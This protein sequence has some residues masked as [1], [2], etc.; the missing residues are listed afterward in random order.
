MRRTRLDDRTA[1]RLTAGAVTPEDAP[2]GYAGV[3]GLLQA[4]RTGAAAQEL[5]YEAATVASMRS[6]LLGH[7]VPLSTSRRKKMISKVLTAKAAAL[8]GVAVLGGGGVAAAATG[9]LPASVQST[10]SSALS[11][12]DISVPNPNHHGHGH[13]HG[14]T[15][16]GSTN[17]SSKSSTAP[18]GQGLKG[19]S[20]LCNAATHNKD[21]QAGTHSRVFSN[22]ST[23]VGTC[24]TASPGKSNGSNANNGGDSSSTNGSTTSGSTDHGNSANHGQ[25]SSNSGGTAGTSGTSTGSGSSGTD[26]GPGH[27]GT[28]GSSHSGGNDSQGASASSHAG[29]KG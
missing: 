15:S 2:P 16:N 12:V 28:T 9:S 22:F 21:S 24:T 6:V 18:N 7:P 1:D 17:D 13:G 10:V 26:S 8:A 11:H 5:P 19:N 23:V 25:G 29:G 3:A 27:A 20:G 14:A 4:A